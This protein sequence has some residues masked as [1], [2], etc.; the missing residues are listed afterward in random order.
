MS[1]TNP[2][3]TPYD[4]MTQTK[5]LQIIKSFIPYL[6]SGQQRQFSMLIQYIQM[7]NCMIIFS[8][9]NQT[10]AAAEANDPAGRRTAM[11]NAVKKFCTPKEQE[12]IDTLLSIFSILDNHE[13][14][15]N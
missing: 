3:F 11:L 15:F 8:E 13:L 10:L 1:E 2:L 12:T 9:S 7:I 6:P 5:E 14:F 4:E